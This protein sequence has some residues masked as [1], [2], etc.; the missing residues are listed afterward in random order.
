VLIAR[1][2]GGRPNDKGD[3]SGIAKNSYY[4]ENGVIAY[5]ISETMVSG[6]LASLLT[7]IVAI[8]AERADVGSG[9]F[10]WIRVGG[11]GIS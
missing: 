9:I 3:F 1:Y 2:S 4:I 5:P 7:N 10:P 8:S 6:N 11:I